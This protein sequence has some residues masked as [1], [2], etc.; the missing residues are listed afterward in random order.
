MR[1]RFYLLTSLLST[2]LLFVT[3]NIANAQLSGVDIDNFQKIEQSIATKATIT[4]V[5]LGLIGIEL[6]WFLLSG[7]QLKTRFKQFMQIASQTDAETAQIPE[8]S[9]ELSPPINPDTYRYCDEISVKIASA[10]DGLQMPKGVLFAEGRIS[11]Q[12]SAK[13]SMS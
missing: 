8:A 5:G 1:F 4:A 13:F 9:I 3:P 6:W 2:G 7:K 10:Y 11:P 12:F